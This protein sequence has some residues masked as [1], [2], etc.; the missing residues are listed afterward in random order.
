LPDE[1]NETRSRQDEPDV[2]LG[3]VLRSEINRDERPES[4]LYVGDEKNE[5]IEPAQAAL[6]R[7]QRRLGALGPSAG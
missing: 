3:P 6:R 5:P 7:R 2:D 1:R 4:G